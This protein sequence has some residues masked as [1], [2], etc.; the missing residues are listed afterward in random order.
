VT[1]ELRAECEFAMH[2]ITGQGDVIRAGRSVLYIFAGLGWPG[3]GLL[4]M[5][6]FVW[7]IELGYRFVA[8]H[9]RF[10][11]RFFFRTDHDA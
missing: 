2:V 5:P 4:A 6:P 10:A 8:N 9:R 7:F 1:E 3:M 11:S